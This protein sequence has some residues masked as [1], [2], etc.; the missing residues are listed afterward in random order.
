[1]DRTVFSPTLDA[2]D[3]AA[4]VRV[5][6]PGKHIVLFGLAATFMLALSTS[7][8][9]SGNM[10]LPHY[11]LPERAAADGNFYAPAEEFL[12]D[13]SPDRFGRISYLKMNARLVALDGAAL[14]EI[15]NK[16]P[17]IKERIAFFLRELSPEDFEGTEAMARVKAEMLKRANLPLASGGASDI[18]I[19]AI[20][21]Q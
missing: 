5:R 1:M 18:V 19:D 8:I 11:E 7:V 20:V 15:K 3:G 4:R 21:I 14:S 10:R 17:Y 6:T 16:Q 2:S 9:T 12:L 13:L